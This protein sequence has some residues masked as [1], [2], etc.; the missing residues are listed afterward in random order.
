MRFAQADAL[1]WLFLLPALGAA[2]LWGMR[3]RRVTL[4]RFAGGRARTGRF[5]GQV[6]SHRRA[7]KTI[8]WLVAAGATIVAAARPQWGTRLEPVTR[9]GVDVV[10]AIDTS[11]SMAAEDAPP[12][13]LEQALNSAS[14][15]I[16]QLAG[17]R[18]GLVSFAGRAT[19]LCPLTVD[20][21]AVKL[22]LSTVDVESVPV[23]GTA[24][25]DALRVAV[26]AFGNEPSSGRSRVI[27]LFTDGEDHEG[28]IE[29]AVGLLE[30]AGVTVYAVGL[31]TNRGAPIPIK[32]STGRITGYKKDREDRIVT[33]RLDETA[34]EQLALA[35][36]GFYARSSSSGIEVE[37]IARALAGMDT[38][39]FGT[40][41]RVRYEERYQIPLGLAL[42]ALIAEACL[43]DRRRQRPDPAVEG[44]S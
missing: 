35:T 33:T 40:T 21:A 3:R 29:E 37:E 12:S 41:L 20:Q 18:V 9:Q 6:S 14:M 5:T 22:F 32:D 13:R 42:A 27:V 24:L 38:T 30:E 11:L 17:N 8:L 34:L 43:S 28:E 31:G 16:D 26:R 39:E 15:L 19:M 25:S 10:I 44:V 36:D 7:V 2:L 1:W 23:P 4:D